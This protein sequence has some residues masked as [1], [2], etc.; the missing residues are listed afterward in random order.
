MENRAISRIVVGVD[1]SAHSRRALSWA[2]REAELWGATLEVVHGWLFPIAI[3]EGTGPSPA[4]PE[5]IEQGSRAVLDAAVGSVG[6][7]GAEVTALLVEG[8]PA[9]V[10]TRAAEGADLL[11]VGSRGHGGFTGLLLGSVSRRCVESASC[12]VVVVPR[13]WEPRPG[14]IVVGVDGSQQSD[15]ALHWA[16]SEATRREARLEVVNAYHETQVVL[17]FGPTTAPDHERL[18]Q[19]SLSLLHH[20]VAGAVGPSGA[21]QVEIVSSPA[22]AAAALHDAAATAELLVV[23][24][25]GRGGLHGLGLG[26]VSHQCVH[27]APCPVVVVRDGHGDAP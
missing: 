24:S 7:T 2:V 19:A 4:D 18:E 3:Y 13:D 27:H 12:P 16:V 17:P 22:G 21:A 23:G 6:T 25:H 26:S 8:E 5:L 11:V 14:T 1:A 20:M 15:A 9:P 10:L